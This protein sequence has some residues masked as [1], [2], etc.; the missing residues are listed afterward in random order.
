MHL[1]L[2]PLVTKAK[3]I[4]FD[5]ND[6]L[7][8]AVK[9]EWAQHKYIARKFYGKKLT[10]VE[11]R[12]HWGKPFTS[13]LTFL[14]ETTH[15]D[16]AMSYNIATKNRF[17][18]TIF[19]DTLATLKFF[20]KEKKKIGLVTATSLHGL[21]CDFQQC[22]IPE[23]YFDYI[24]TEDDTVFHKPDPRV[25][26]PTLKWLAENHIEP[27]EVVYVGDHLKDAEAAI[28][29]GFQFVGVTTGITPAEE[30]SKRGIP[31]VPQLSD[32]YSQ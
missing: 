11:L 18:K 4:C 26:E 12:F 10:D 7:V 1:E 28:T 8:E 13:L 21:R 20:R 25:F 3:A 27:F 30:F 2:L 15:I 31:C 32:L 23:N 24:Q 16:M 14:Y 17:P 29:A 9:A 5:H 22:G 19:R 6:T